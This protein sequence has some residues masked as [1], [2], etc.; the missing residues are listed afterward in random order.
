MLPGKV[1]LKLYV[2]TR[3]L[4]LRRRHAELFDAGRYLPVEVRGRMRDQ[5]D[6]LAENQADF[7]ALISVADSKYRRPFLRHRRRRQSPAR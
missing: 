2:L 6:D 5:A 7:A 1:R 4:R 3:S